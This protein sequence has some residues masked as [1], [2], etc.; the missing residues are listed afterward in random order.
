M[1]F[2]CLRTNDG[3][4]F[5]H[6][7]IRCSLGNNFAFLTSVDISH[8]IFISHVRHDGTTANICDDEEFNQTADGLLTTAGIKDGTRLRSFHAVLIDLS[9]AL[10]DKFCP[11]IA[12]VSDGTRRLST[13]VGCGEAVDDNRRPLRR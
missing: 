12:T 3:D 13:Q 1:L 7:D 10:V 6:E 5:M 9:D 2:E 4:G 8:E 11:M